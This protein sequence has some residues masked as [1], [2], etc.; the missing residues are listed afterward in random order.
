MAIGFKHRKWMAYLFISAS[1]PEFSPIFEDAGRYFRPRLAADLRYTT[2]DVDF[3]EDHFN[4][5]N[6]DAGKEEFHQRLRNPTYD[7]FNQAMVNIYSWLEQFSTCPDWDGGGLHFCFAGHG[8]DSD[9]AL[10]L[11]DSIITPDNFIN[12][13]TNTA[14]K[15]SL[16][17]RLR[18]SAVL[19][20][21][22]SGAFV[23]KLLDCCLNEYSDL[24]V[25]FNL[26]SSCMED[27][28]AWEESGLGHGLFTY[29]FSVK[30]YSLTSIAAK[31][32]Q[33]NN[34]FGPSLAIIG[35]EFGC[36]LLTSGAQNP[37]AYW[38]G[39]G[40]LEVCKQS[41]SL[42]D[43]SKT[44]NLDVMRSK[45]KKERDAFVK[46]IQPLTNKSFIPHRIT[47]DEDMKASLREEMNF[48]LAQRRF[49]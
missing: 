31:A 33:P 27:E 30:E 11:S 24:L 45:L 40:Y 29:C 47:S 48:I 42:F 25:P 7:E 39:A 19:D 4:K 6:Y 13:L 21:C 10:V 12:F 22:H 49:S 35:R 46:L 37:I 36:S 2:A 23:T 1:G 17:G 18:V 16:P 15:I 44:I 8:R 9:G 20:S 32:V 26:F 41:I 3:L 5:H 14:R 43:G 34:S 28:F 38:N